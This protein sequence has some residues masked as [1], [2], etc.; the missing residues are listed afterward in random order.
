MISQDFVRARS[1][2]DSRTVV[3]ATLIV[4]TQLLGA[5]CLALF[6]APVFWLPAFV[7]ICACVSGMQLWVHEASHYGLFR[8]RRLNDMWATLFFA[9]PIGMSVKI[10]RRAHM[11]HHAHLATPQDK[12]RFAFNV[13]IHGRRNLWRVIARGLLCIEGCHIALKKYSGISGESPETDRGSM[14]YTIAFNV[15]L[16]AA[17]I[18]AGRW[19]HYLLMW[20]YPILGVAVTFNMLRSIGEHQPDDWRGVA[21]D[22]E[23]IPPVIRSTTPGF[24]EKWLMFQANFNYHFEHH[25]YPS[26][27]ATRL[28]ELHKRLADQA[29]FTR[30]PELIQGSAVGRVLKMSGTAQ[31]DNS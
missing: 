27:V 4:W 19:Y 1:V 10:Y 3:G 17:C 14:I 29:F 25:L 6:A 16:L 24:F 7:M 12:D 21:S 15:A 23:P 31:P 13:D 18:Y 11:T 28:P 30:Y 22:K 9:G 20:V 2:P 5:W 8:G 26:V